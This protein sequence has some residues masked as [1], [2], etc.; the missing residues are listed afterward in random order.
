MTD[1]NFERKGNDIYTS[2]E[3]P[4]TEAILGARVNVKTLSST[5]SLTIPAGTQP[6]TQLRLKGQGLAVSN[7]PG[8]L[9]VEIKVTL[10]KTLTDKQKKIIEEW[11]E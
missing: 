10:P 11:G 7:P 6:G 1:Q 9:F 3:I 2:V 4:F 8:D 5:V